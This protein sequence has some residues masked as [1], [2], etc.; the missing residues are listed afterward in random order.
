MAEPEEYTVLA[1][2]DT[3]VLRFPRLT[4]EEASLI[5]ERW[6]ASV[7]G[8]SLAIVECA[9]P[10]EITPSPHGHLIGKCV[11]AG[12]DQHTV[13]IGTLLS[14]GDAGTLVIKDD[15]GEIHHCWPMLEIQECPID[16]AE[17]TDAGSA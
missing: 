3:L 6:K 15:E 1:P 7:S 17:V 5:R 11:L 13:V 16:H 12:I 4:A 9:T 14:I 10:F 2:E 8:G